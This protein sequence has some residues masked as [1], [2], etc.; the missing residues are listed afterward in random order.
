MEYNFNLPK[1]YLS[2]S[3]YDLWKKNKEQYRKRYY[4]NEPSIETVETKFGKHTDSFLDNGGHIDGVI[5]YSHNQYR[6]ET[7]YCGV[8]LLGY[9]DG[10]DEK[11][12]S[13]LERKTGHKNPKGKVP[14]DKLKVHKHQQLVFYSLMVELFHGKVHP[15][16]I[17]QWL[18]TDFKTK[19]ME[20]QGHI[21]TSG[22]REL[23]L[24]GNIKTFKRKIAKWEKE[25][26][27]KDILLVAKEIHEDYNKRI[28][29]GTC[30]EVAQ[31]ES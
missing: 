11:T 3:Q 28:L 17:L 30:E 12:L 9:L 31:K 14:W 1:K 15:T 21:L 4:F 18:E 16:V 23:K 22:S 25:N 8:P 2:Y 7:N 19:E 29:L 10:F 6:I 26:L 5:Q 20:F 27:K 24:T 13:I